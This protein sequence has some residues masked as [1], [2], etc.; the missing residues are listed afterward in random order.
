MS[1]SVFLGPTLSLE[2]ARAIWDYPVYLP[3]V[4]QGDVYAAARRRPVAIGIV[5]GYFKGVPA[6]WHKE[7]LWAM[8]QGIHVFGAASMG[9]LRAA[10]LS[11]FG[12]RGIGEIHASLQ[13]G[14]L[15]DDDEVAVLHGPAELGHVAVS[16]A[17]VN[18]RATVARAVEER[19]VSRN[20][21]T[22]LLDLA[23]SRPYGER[24]YDTLIDDAK[25]DL[26]ID[27]TSIDALA[28]WLPVGRVDQ[29]AMDAEAMLTTLRDTIQELHMPLVVDFRFE[30]TEAWQQV[31]QRDLSTRPAP[32]SVE[33][34]ALEQIKLD[35]TWQQLS[36]AALLRHTLSFRG[37]LPDR[38]LDPERLA[39]TRDML[40]QTHELWRADELA[41]WMEAN[42]LDEQGFAALVVSEAQVHGTAASVASL[43]ADIVRELQIRG[44]Y[45]QRLADAE[46]LRHDLAAIDAHW[47]V[48]ADD[49]DAPTLHALL[50]AAG[51]DIPVDNMSA[52]SR[53]F[54]FESIEAWRHALLHRYRARQATD[55][56]HERK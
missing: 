42:G 54:G 22:R 40:R 9:A 48:H 44:D 43:D 39:G 26:T 27:T 36:R 49:N 28:D 46:R 4:R 45:A 41:A 24:R 33:A 25:S 16:D 2:R 11:V 35:G 37:G 19:I 38:M 56:D 32:G 18:I 12:M 23:K 30:H 7:I 3:P 15:E 10:E 14:A 52:R 20:E 1:V 5:D 31:V 17:M 29:K 21:A 13:R 8:S 34:L 51:I 47:Y 53:W 50:V 55:G 6:V